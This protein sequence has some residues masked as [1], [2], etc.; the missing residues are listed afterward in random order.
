MVAATG[1][2]LFIGLL[3]GRFVDS[4]IVLKLAWSGGGEVRGR[5]SGP[6]VGVIELHNGFKTYKLILNN[7]YQKSH[8]HL[9]L[10]RSKT[11]FIK[12]S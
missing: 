7:S 8:S 4:F 10:R 5:L 2:I 11:S 1:I 9:S 6:V 3:R 12:S